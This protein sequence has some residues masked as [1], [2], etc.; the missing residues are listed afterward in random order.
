[1]QLKTGRFIFEL[2]GNKLKGGFSIAHL[3]GRGK[4]NQWLL[5]KR[6]DE[7]ANPTFKLEVALTEEKRKKLEVKVPLSESDSAS[8]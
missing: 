2:K 1:M 8:P 6:R 5:I 4:G 7:Q 3:K